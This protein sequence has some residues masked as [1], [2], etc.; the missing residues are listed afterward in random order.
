VILSRGVLTFAF[1]GLDAFI[2]FAITNG[3]GLSTLV[4]SVAVT[5][6]TVSWTCAAWIQDRWIIR[7]GEA[8]FIR[9]GYCSLAIGVVIVAFGARPDAAPFWTIHVGAVFAGLGMGLAYAAHTQLTL[10]SA[11]DDAVG[12]ATASMQLSDNLGIALGTGV[13]GAIVTF[14]DDAGWAAG[15]S[16]AV[17]Y[18]VPLAVAVGGIAVV[19][20]F[21]L[22]GS[23]AVAGPE[24][25][26]AS[27]IRER[28]RTGVDG[29]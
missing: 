19:G 12:S 28:R 25:P 9:A 1:F 24:V 4:G 27:V 11:P 14:G 16:V 15:N 22:S 8:R 13:V 18:L 23:D 20:R 29:V 21:A 7:L 17:A 2:P 10:R 6:V 26:R 5:V 3:R